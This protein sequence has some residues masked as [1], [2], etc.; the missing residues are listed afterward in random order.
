MRRR[1]HTLRNERG[2]ALILAIMVLLCLTGLVLSYLSVSALEPQISR[3]L[4]DGTRL[5]YL[6]EAGIERGYN[7]L[8][9]TGDWNTV[10]GG[11]T[12][13]APWVALAGLTN[14]AITGATNGG[15]FS[16]TVRN[17]NGAADTPFTGLS[18]TT[19]P[20]MDSSPT[21]ENNGVLIM[22]STATFNGATKTLEVVVR[23]T[24]LPSF[25]GAVNTPGRQDDTYINTTAF[26][27]DGRDYA[28]TL[29]GNGCDTASNWTTTANPMKYGQATQPGT[30]TNISTS[31]ETNAE[32]A[33]NTT[34]KQ[35]NV[36]GKSQTSG[37]FTS[38][39][40]TVSPDASL[41]PSAMD[42]FI[43]LVASNPATNV[44]QSTQACPMVLTG[45]TSGLTNTPTLTNGCSTNATLNLGSRDDPKLV[46]FRGDLDPTSNFTGLA[47]N[48]GIKGAGIL[49]IQDGD[50]KNFGTL[51]WDGLVIVTGSYTGMGLMNGSTTTIRGAA[52]AY[53]AQAGEASGFFELYLGTVNSASIRSSKQDVDMVQLMRSMH[54]ITN[55]REV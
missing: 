55:W 38:G 43:N 54:S 26:T 49:V 22:R 36:M 8:T 9:R 13:G 5:R 51:E 41:N 19:V 53:E 10:L 17:D 4:S 35:N 33:Y 29:P 20:P 34:A 50:M 11:A 21:A 7:M 18:N 31:Y 23:R 2:V 46:F 3:N 44:L 30:Q 52:V 12:V 15:T 1:R 42:N 37:A 48:S 32:N 27:F 39:L 6:A 47:L 28:C 25:P 24:Q 16:V 40:N 14:A 45:S